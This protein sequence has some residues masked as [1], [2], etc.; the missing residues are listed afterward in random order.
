MS[1][2]VPMK[3]LPFIQ[4]GELPDLSGAL[5][6]L[7]NGMDPETWYVDDPVTQGVAKGYCMICPR[8]PRGDDACYQRGLDEERRTGFLAFGIRGGR[9]ASQRQRILDV[10]RISREIGLAE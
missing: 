3:A 4:I 1:G 8:G 5:C 10:D 2:G 7:T 9:T 6:D